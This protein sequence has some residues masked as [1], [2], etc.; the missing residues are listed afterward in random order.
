M[1][2][3]WKILGAVLSV[4][5]FLVT[6]AACGLLVYQIVKLNV[7]NEKFLILI[8]IILLLLCLIGF[9]LTY[10]HKIVGNIFAGIVNWIFRIWIFLF[11][12][13]RNNIE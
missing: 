6:L 12:K 5:I 1:K 13:D 11:E 4:C 2:K 8:G 9:L 7:L 3:F 10:S